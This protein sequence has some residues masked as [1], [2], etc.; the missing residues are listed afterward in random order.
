MGSKKR[1]AERQKI[2]EGEGDGESRDSVR[3]REVFK[4]SMP[5]LHF[6]NHFERT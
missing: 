5:S 4:S 6:L 2:V 3:R 1:G